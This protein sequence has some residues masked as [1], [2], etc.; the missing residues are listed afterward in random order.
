MQKLKLRKALRVPLLAVI[1]LELTSSCLLSLLSLN[2]YNS[3]AGAVT[4]WMLSN[5]KNSTIHLSSQPCCLN[6]TE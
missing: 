1:N 6:W 3:I 5:Q 4:P 2:S